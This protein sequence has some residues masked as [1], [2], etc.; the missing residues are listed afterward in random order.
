MVIIGFSTFAIEVYDWVEDLKG[1]ILMPR[2]HFGDRA[3]DGRGFK[4]PG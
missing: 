2:S 3:Y 1:L 4:V